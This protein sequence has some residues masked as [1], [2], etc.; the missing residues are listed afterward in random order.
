MVE[1]VDIR[2]INTHFLINELF[3]GNADKALN[4]SR[5]YTGTQIT[6]AAKSIERYMILNYIKTGSTNKEIIE[7]LSRDGY[8]I[9]ADRVRRLRKEFNN[10]KNK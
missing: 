5:R 10:A 7:V 3:D 8:E 4:V 2:E 6:L 9:R 1:E